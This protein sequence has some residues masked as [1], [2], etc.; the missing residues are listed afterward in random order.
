MGFTT[1][2]SSLLLASSLDLKGL[3][4]VGAPPSTALW[5]VAV[6][7][8]C[9]PTRSTA[10]YSLLELWVLERGYRLIEVE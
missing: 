6:K 7:T 10:R 1:V 8:A 2:V 3:P 5:P 4:M 9:R